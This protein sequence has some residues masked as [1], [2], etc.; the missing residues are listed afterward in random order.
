MSVNRDDPDGPDQG[1]NTEFKGR[2]ALDGQELLGAS[3]EVMRPDPGRPYV[4]GGLPEPDDLP[5]SG[6]PDRQPDRRNRSGPI[7]TSAKEEAMGQAIELLDA[8]GVPGRSRQGPEPTRTSSRAACVQRAMIAMALSLEPEI[9]IADEPTTALDVTIQAQIP[10]A[11][12]LN[13]DF[14]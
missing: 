8:V 4:N 3:N 13:R 14:N 1:P 11:Q 7:A 12:A 6:P 9:P 10:D 2:S 5:E